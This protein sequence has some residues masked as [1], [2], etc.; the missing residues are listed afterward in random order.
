[1]SLGLKMKNLSAGADYGSETVLSREFQG[2]Q[3]QANQFLSPLQQSTKSPVNPS[4][5]CRI[6]TGDG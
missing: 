5:L 2:A 6:F 1:M 3:M 4:R